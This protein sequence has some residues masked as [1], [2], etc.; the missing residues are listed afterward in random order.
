MQEFGRF[1]EHFPPLKSDLVF[2]LEVAI[3]LHEDGL[4]FLLCG[5]FSAL[6]PTD[7]MH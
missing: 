3:K 5:D 6:Q 4:D 1:F 2:C 7:A